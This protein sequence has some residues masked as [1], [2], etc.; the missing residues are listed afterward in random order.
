MP[1]HNIDGLL[2]EI[3]NAIKQQMRR[4][5]DLSR[6]FICEHDLREI[7]GNFQLQT[8]FPS[9]SWDAQTI[10][11]IR[12]KYLKVLSILIYVGTNSLDLR[13]YFRAHFINH[14]NQR[15]DQNLPLSLSELSF[16]Q[17]AHSDL[18]YEQQYAF[19]PVVIEEHESSHVQMVE[20]NRRLP[21]I[22]DS[23]EI[24]WGGYGRITEVEIAPRQLYNQAKQLENPRVCPILCLD[25]LRKLIDL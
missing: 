14:P 5:G 2:R 3:Y 16:L 9:R 13:A 8:I 24:G 25:G 7:W 20:S 1:P 12:N 22:E 17:G 23:N 21:F 10:N 18:F 4:P 11:L 19:I 15:S 6:R